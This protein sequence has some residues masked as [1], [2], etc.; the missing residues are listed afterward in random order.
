MRVHVHFAVVGSRQH[1]V[2]LQ[3]NYRANVDAAKRA[4]LAAPLSRHFGNAYQ[5]VPVSHWRCINRK[6]DCGTSKV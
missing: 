5:P 6:N 2:E 1:Q 3:V 4:T